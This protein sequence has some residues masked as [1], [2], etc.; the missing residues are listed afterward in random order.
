[1]RTYVL[2]TA[3]LYE[4]WYTPRRLMQTIKAERGA[5]GRRRQDR[6]KLQPPSRHKYRPQARAYYNAMMYTSTWYVALACPAHPFRSGPAWGQ[7]TWNLTGLSP[8]RGHLE[9]DGLAPKTSQI[10]SSLPPKRDCSPKR[11][12]RKNENRSTQ[13]SRKVI[14]Q[15]C[16]DIEQKAEYIIIS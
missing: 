15:Q 3:K 16:N 2:P 10:I 4:Y 7:S 14:L 1:M 5:C 6:P 11:V 13:T 12:E 9:F 8:K